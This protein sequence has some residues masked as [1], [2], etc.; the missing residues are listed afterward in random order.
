[1]RWLDR[2]RAGGALAYG[3]KSTGS[4]LSSQARIGYPNVLVSMAFQSFVFHDRRD[5]GRILAGRL[6]GLDVEAPV[7]IA[8]P[9]GG[10]PVG[11][12]VARALDAPMD[13][14]L[15]RKL[16]APGQPEL[17][18]GALG[19]DGTV[20]LDEEALA[21]GLVTRAQI[22]R[23]VAREAAELERRRRLYRGDL[24]AIDVGDRTVLVIDDGIATGV[25]A[26][27]ATQVLRARGAARIVVAVPVCSIGA[28]ERLRDQL[29]ELICLERPARFGGVGAWYDD[30]SQ[31]ADR[32]VI[33]LLRASRSPRRE[34]DQR[35]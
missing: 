5:A 29:D 25:T 18:I 27:A 6:Q 8:L 1:V 9:R 3:P 30:F 21:S 24:P 13:V 17:G 12:E 14:G 11:Y 7:I 16:G 26:A 22:E 4:T 2:E 34:L 28:S 35:R 31:T 32:E 20:V 10:V 23:T 33:T 15:V 19:E